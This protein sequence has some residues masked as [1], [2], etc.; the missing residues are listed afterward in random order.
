MI[1]ILE[2]HFKSSNYL[3]RW[4]D[5]SRAI[6]DCSKAERCNIDAIIESVNAIPLHLGVTDANAAENLR[7]CPK[8]SDSWSRYQKAILLIKP[9]PHHPNFLTQSVVDLKMDVFSS[10]GNNSPE[11]VRKNQDRWTSNHDEYLH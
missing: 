4:P 11:F 2:L 8:H 6:P 1:G 3:S 7:N 9:T 10:F 5:R